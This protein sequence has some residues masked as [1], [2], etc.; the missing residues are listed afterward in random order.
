METLEKEVYQP[1]IRLNVTSDFRPKMWL[2]I[3][4]A[5][6]D[7][8]F[9]DYTKLNGD[10]VADNHHLTYSSTGVGQI[11]D[12]EKVSHKTNNWNSMRGRLD[13]GD[14]VAMAFSSKSALRAYDENWPPGLH[15][16]EYG[17]RS[18]GNSMRNGSQ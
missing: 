4:E 7:T 6:P 15:F 9:Y 8:M 16:P 17:S 13:R 10:K 2:P 11:I 3:F 1:A 12:G 18:I 5:H 14:N